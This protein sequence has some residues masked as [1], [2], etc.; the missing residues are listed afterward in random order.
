MPVEL[1]D[2]APRAAAALL[3]E[4]L[5]AGAARA[6]ERELGGDE[7]AVEEDEDDE[8]D[9]ARGRSS[10][11]RSGQGLEPALTGRGRRASAAAGRS[12]YFEG[13]RRQS[14][15]TAQG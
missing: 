1:A 5:E 13:G 3:R 15:A 6:H 4:G 9:A 7:H 14:S 8:R 2:D 12:R 10:L 11:S